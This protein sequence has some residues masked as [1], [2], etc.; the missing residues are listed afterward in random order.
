MAD[1]SKI[2]ARFLEA[3][4]TGEKL[5]HR[6]T[7]RACGA[8]MWEPDLLREVVKLD[9]HPMAQ[10]KFLEQW[11]KVALWQKIRASVG[12]DD[13]WFASLR[14]LLPPYDGPEVQLLRGQRINEAVGMSWTRSWNIAQMFARYG[15]AVDHEMRY[16]KPRDGE[17]IEATLHKEI[18]CAPCLLPIRPH[19]KAFGYHKEGEYIVDPRTV[20]ATSI[21]KLEAA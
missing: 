16:T 11:T 8:V 20:K 14:K 19:D 17:V 6:V 7:I 10:A 21:L 1:D 15:T 5:T 12:D 18:I 3:L 13:L 2:V 9:V 4:A